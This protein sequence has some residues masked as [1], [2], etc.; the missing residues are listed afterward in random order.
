MKNKLLYLLATSIAIAGAYSCSDNDENGGGDRNSDKMLSVRALLYGSTRVDCNAFEKNQ[1]IRV[2]YNHY[3]LN[4]TYEFLQGVYQSPDSEDVND[5]WADIPWAPNPGDDEAKSIYLEDIKAPNSDNEWFFTATTYPEPNVENENYN[6]YQVESDQTAAEKF[7]AGDFL[8]ARAVY[9]NDSWKSSGIRLHFRH[10]LSRLVVKVI[11]PQGLEADGYFPS[12]GSV[13]MTATV[14]KKYTQYSVIYNNQVRDG[15]LFTVNES[16]GG[17][18]VDVRMHKIG[19]KDITISA[20][21]AAEHTFSA[22]IPAQYTGMDALLSFVINGKNYS[23]KPATAN[24]V[25]LKQ[26][27]ITNI[28]LIMLSGA[29]NQKLVLN[30]VTLTPWIVDKAEVGDL[31]PEE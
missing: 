30:K 3:N 11:L 23:Y 8:A 9:T 24:T 4:T 31:I 12:P 7:A 29:G 1:K 10:L 2:Y 21:A 26:E 20:G 6:V 15:E 18:M 16:T 17:P 13:T 14:N 27:H 25:V 22:I 19:T 5:K 28:Q